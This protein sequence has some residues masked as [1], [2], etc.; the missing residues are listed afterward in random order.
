MA[1]LKRAIESGSI[2]DVPRMGAKAVDKIKAAIAHA[3]TGEQRLPIGRALPLVESVIET[4]RRSDGV[5]EIAYAGSLRRGRDT[6]GDLDI[7]VAAKDPGK[8]SETFRTMP[9][10][11]SVLAAGDNK[12]SVRLAIKGTAGRLGGE[13]VSTIQADLRVVPRESWGAALMYFTGSK[14]H[15]VKL[16]E[17]AQKMGLTLN[18]YGL[19]PEDE[20]KTPP[21]SRGVK[22]VASRTEVEIYAALKTPFVPAEIR[23]ARG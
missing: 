5:E 3:E 7:L 19:F 10:V 22:P 20:E 2:L 4:L 15:N 23:E 9:Q 6:V 21:Q 11:V 12:S 18:E 13:H 1:S 17:R 16:R 14:E 8:V